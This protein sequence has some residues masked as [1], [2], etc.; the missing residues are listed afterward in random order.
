MIRQANKYDKTEVIDMMLQ[1]KN[2]SGITSLQNINNQS[3]WE[4]LFDSIVSGKGIIFLE[5]EKG[6][7]IGLVNQ[8]IW[9]D[10]TFGLHELAWWVKPEFRGSTVGYKLLKSFLAYGEQ[11][12]QEGRIKYIVLSQLAGHSEFDYAR[13]GFAKTDENWMK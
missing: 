6:L 1:F 13:F 12:K 4:K 7:M 10:K 8:S 11:L 3:Y 9:C 2:E 5:P